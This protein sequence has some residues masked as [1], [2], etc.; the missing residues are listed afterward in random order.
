MPASISMI[1]LLPKFLKELSK[2]VIFFSNAAKSMPEILAAKILLFCVATV[3]SSA[4]SISSNSFSPGL[5]PV[6]TMAISLSNCN[7]DSRI[8][9]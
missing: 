9:S 3:P 8:I 7:P 4:V 5:N 6:K 2:S 1:S